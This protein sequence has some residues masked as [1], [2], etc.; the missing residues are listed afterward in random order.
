MADIRVRR[1]I[2]SILTLGFFTLGAIL[3]V[4]GVALTFVASPRVSPVFAAGTQS[5]YAIRIGGYIKLHAD[6]YLGDVPSLEKAGVEGE[7]SNYLASGRSAGIRQDLEL[8]LDSR[9]RDRYQLYVSLN[10]HGYWGV[11]YASDGSYGVPPTTGPLLI[12]QAYLGYYGDR[13]KVNAGRLYFSLGPVGLIARND[14]SAIEGLAVDTMLGGFYLAGI[15][16]RLSS[17]YDPS[18]VVVRGADDFVALRVARRMGDFLVG[19]NHVLSGL[20]DESAQ[21]IDFEGAIYNRRVRGEIARMRPST[22]SFDGNGDGD[23]YDTGW[24]PAFFVEGDILNRPS[25]RLTLSYGYFARGFTP[26]FTSLYDEGDEKGIGF[27][28][29]TE[30]LRLKYDRVLSGAVHLEAGLSRLKFIDEQYAHETGTDRTTPLT[31]AWV[32]LAKGIGENM[33]AGIRYT[34]RS[35]DY[36]DYGCVSASLSAGF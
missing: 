3:C 5:Q 19:Y 21:S 36:M 26:T 27:A 4:F 6:Y 10:S 1:G 18:G 14:Y 9:V 23:K 35:N 16:S 34:Q 24:R 28:H 2:S 20:G 7:G 30:G 11:Q 22:T 32:G 17:Q 29:N 31:M 15:Y 33:E 25:G 12:D 13:L 8:F